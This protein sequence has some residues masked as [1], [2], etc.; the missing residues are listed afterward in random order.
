MAS[1]CSK[2]WHDKIIRLSV[3]KLHPI[4]GNGIW[5][6]Q[7]NSSSSLVRFDQWGVLEKDKI[8][9][10]WATAA[11]LMDIKLQIWMSCMASFYL[12]QNIA[13]KIFCL[14]FS[15][16]PSTLSS[17]FSSS[18][19]KHFTSPL[20][21]APLPSSPLPALCSLPALLFWLLSLSSKS[22]EHFAPFLLCH[23]VALEQPSD[24]SRPNTVPPLTSNPSLKIPHVAVLVC[25]GTDFLPMIWCI[26]G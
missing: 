20:L 19:L 10:W 15:L 17:S 1:W 8:K 2:W 14:A 26:E 4:S 18:L 23:P 13:A 21:V 3:G 12:I 25:Q 7:F 6:F 9:G 16:F 11:G 22:T 24:Y 5:Q